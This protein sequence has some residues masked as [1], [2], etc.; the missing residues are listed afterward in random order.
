MDKWVTLEPV[1]L[2][3]QLTSGSSSARPLKPPPSRATF[4]GRLPAEVHLIILQH[5][6]VY[7]IP[8][9][10]R[11][12]RALGRL[13]KD[14]KL[15]E[16]RWLA[17]GVEKHKLDGVL[18]ELDDQQKSKP[19]APG[20]PTL[21]VVEDDDF[22]DF[23]SPQSAGGL[24]ADTGDLADFVL[25]STSYAQPASTTVL[26][27]VQPVPGSSVHRNKYTR[28]HALLK[29]LTKHLSA[30][31]HLVLSSLFPGNQTLR[32]QAKTLQLLL[33]FVSARVQPLRAWPT[34]L[35]SLRATIDRFQAHLLT[36][37][38]IADQKKDEKGMHDAAHSSW[39]VVDRDSTEEW[40]IG[41][42]WSEKRE[43]F[44][45]QGKWQALENFTQDRALVFDPM[46]EFMNHIADIL[47]VDGA[48]AI[49]IF[50]PDSRVLLNFADRVAVEVVGEYIIPLLSHARAVSNQ[51]FLRATAAS[52]AQAWRIA[53]VLLDISKPPP[54]EPDRPPVVTQLQA[55]DVVYR[56][57]EVNMDEYLDE[58]IE[59]IKATFD[60][61]CR[62]WDKKL[63]S[64][65]Q[66]SSTF[67]GSHNPALV[68]RNV[69]ASFTE[70]LLLPV[71]LVP[72]A[73]G[74]AVVGAATAATTVASA[75]NPQRWVMGSAQNVTT[76]GG[77]YLAPNQDTLEAFIDD[78]DG[79][80]SPRREQPPQPTIDTLNIPETN[81]ADRPS[82]ATSVTTAAAKSAFEHLD[83]LLSLDVALELIQTDRDSLKRVES[84][85]GYP[86]TYGHK[87][88]ETIEELFILLLQ[89]LSERH[90]AP[91]FATATER[92][93]MYK[94]A[95]HEETTSVAPLL[96]FF[97]LVHLGDTIQS[98]VQV[99]FDKELAPYIS[100]TD[101][102]NGAVRE[103]KRF[104]NTLDDAVAGGLNAGTDVLMQQVEHIIWSRT[105]ARDY[106]PEE[107]ASLDLKP[108]K[109]CQEA[110]ACL[111]MHCKLL[112]GSTSKDVLEVFYQEIGIRLHQI[113]QKHIKRQI[114]SL[115]GGFQ[116]IA[117]LNAYHA[118]IQTLR[119]PQGIQDFAHLKMLGHVYIVSDAVD[120]AQIV[121][122]VQRYGGT[123]RPEDIYEFVQRRSD[124]KKIE[125]T[126]DK[127]MYNLSFKEDCVIC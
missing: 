14:D 88:R 56:M 94:P 13:T 39:D 1:K 12:C 18:D 45:E 65:T 52:F 49:R 9:Y 121:K 15:W 81:G 69:L 120:L 48:T 38:D 93:R 17:L 4:I 43:I 97:E 105:G 27:A 51:T 123:F 29:G 116:V 85:K 24:A 110:I 98:M 62:E 106:Y 72:R 73:V 67:L 55:E 74:G 108:T 3:G 7:D 8:G 111:E 109:A 68:K 46:V 122:D 63:E 23:A 96:Q 78:D 20:P 33:R 64:H 77:K 36:A 44:Y 107:G 124:W 117:D 19:Q 99:Y 59:Y 114:I 40:E 92:M 60:A 37:F 50:P 95:E 31:P 57:F 28:A 112:R 90:I 71:T 87:V 75:L 32:Q 21:S 113:L 42:M 103:K 47:R 35:L 84:F 30:P 126:V 79:E 83:L 10:S 53:D 127:T 119:V 11:I 70:A 41:R 6:P 118:F 61:T 80:M 16:H 66:T 91:G 89:A 2:Y 102:L 76:N 82:S 125:K 26:F 100:R 25:P 101:F 22:G 86:G 104:E 58:E 115:E 5:L 54:S 34:L